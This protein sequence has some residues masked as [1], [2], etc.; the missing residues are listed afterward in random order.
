MI[1]VAGSGAMGAGIAQL[2]SS[3]GFNVLL[4]DLNDSLLHQAKERMYAAMGKSIEKGKM[5]EE[6]REEAVKRL[7]TTTD[8]VQFK[9]CDLV[10]EAIVEDL[11]AKQEIFRKL[12]AILKPEALIVTNTSGISITAIAEATTRPHQVAGMHFF[13]SRTHYEARRSNKRV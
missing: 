7:E 2:A 1:G 5:T 11:T 10:I 4:W 8:L 13:Q 12:D 9:A 3:K 6:Q